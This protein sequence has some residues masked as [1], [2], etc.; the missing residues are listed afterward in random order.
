[1][2]W[3]LSNQ[4]NFQVIIALRNKNKEKLRNHG[5]IKILEITSQLGFQLKMVLKTAVGDTHTLQPNSKYCK[6]A[7]H[8]DCSLSSWIV[9]PSL[10]SVMVSNLP[11]MLVLLWNS[12]QNNSHDLK[13]ILTRSAHG[14][15]VSLR[16]HC[17]LRIT[18]M[19]KSSQSLIQ[20]KFELLVSYIDIHADRKVL[21]TKTVLLIASRPVKSSDSLTRVWNFGNLIRF[22]S[23]TSILCYCRRNT[24]IPIN[25]IER[26]VSHVHNTIFASMSTVDSIGIFILSHKC[27]LKSAGTKIIIFQDPLILFRFSVFTCEIFFPHNFVYL[28][29]IHTT[30]N[31]SFFVSPLS[32]TIR[33]NHHNFLMFT[34]C[35]QCNAMHFTNFIIKLVKLLGVC[36]GKELLFVNI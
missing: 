30:K 18:L 36:N 32:S 9:N 11:G 8:D 29:T 10:L 27:S 20:F 24:L 5:K 33:S 31:S 15:L 23:N 4:K 19:A 34:I 22:A 12:L 21:P 16:Y 2:P 26:P 13:W 17:A 25:A 28:G 14:N 6:F 35:M 7:L 3:N 1:M